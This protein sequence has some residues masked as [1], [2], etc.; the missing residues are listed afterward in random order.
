[1]YTNIQINRNNNNDNG[2]IDAI[3]IGECTNKTTSNDDY[4]NDNDKREL[5]NKVVNNVI[6]EASNLCINGN[7]S[8]DNSNNKNFKLIGN[9]VIRT[10]KIECLIT[11]MGS[12]T[13][14]NNPVTNKFST[15]YQQN[16]TIA[17]FLLK[18]D[19]IANKYMNNTINEKTNN[20]NNNNSS[21]GDNNKNNNNNN[22]INNTNNMRKTRA[23]IRI[24]QQNYKKAKNYCAPSEELTR[25][26]IRE[27]IRKMR[28]PK[29]TEIKNI[30][31]IIGFNQFINHK[32]YIKTPLFIRNKLAISMPRLFL[33]KRTRFYKTLS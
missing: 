27:D 21:I 8:N 3:I 12:Y 32:A 6:N 13:N 11:K 33:Q 1:M 29:M 28:N 10:N 7:N 24:E 25:L 30:L 16:E 19:E 22:N 26:Q 4:T 31:K 5:V 2:K 18:S 17:G 15:Y 14:T 20:D 23:R 9:N